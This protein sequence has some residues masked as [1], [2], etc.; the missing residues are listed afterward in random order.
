MRVLTLLVHDLHP[1]ENWACH[2]YEKLWNL[3]QWL[4]SCVFEGFRIYFLSY[5]VEMPIYYSSLAER[6]D[7]IERTLLSHYH[8]QILYYLFQTV[9][10][11][12]LSK[13]L[14]LLRL[15]K[16]QPRLKFAIWIAQKSLKFFRWLFLRLKGSINYCKIHNFVKNLSEMS[17]LILHN[18]SV[19]IIAMQTKHAQLSRLFEL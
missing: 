12:W 6:K 15:C 9:N 11:I 4:S 16:Y 1:W 18:T 8:C 13:F 5:P 10:T 3:E 19:C 14:A 17:H 2:L 7:A